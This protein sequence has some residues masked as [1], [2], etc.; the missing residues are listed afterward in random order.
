M[1]GAPPKSPTPSPS[2]SPSASPSPS[3]SAT[4][5]PTPT[6]SASP[7]PTPTPTA[8]LR[9]LPSPLYGVTTDAITPLSDI[10]KALAGLSRMP[11]T[12]IV[13]DEWVAATQYTTAIAQIR[14]VSYIMGELLDS[15][16]VK[17]YTVDQYKARVDEY[18]NAFGSSVDLWEIGNEINGEWLGDTPTVVSKMTAAYDKVKAKGLRTEL[19]LYYNKDCWAK[20][21]NEMFKWAQ[22]NIP[23]RMKQGL[24]YVLISYY[25]DDCNGLKPD[26]PT[27]FHQLAQMFPNSKIGMG[28]IGTTKAANKAD[29]IQRYYDMKISEPNYVGGYFWWYFRQDMVPMTKALWSTLNEAIRN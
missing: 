15:Y 8:G 23:D 29:Y 5:S 20:P 2:P 14:P 9:P 16:Y 17:Q 25:E 21:A 3:P 18:L 24:D 1:A 13:F 11:T 12:R 4:P 10:V 7:S 19:T 22:T 26:W 28:E 6:P 27:V